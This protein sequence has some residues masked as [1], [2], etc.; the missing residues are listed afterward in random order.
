[1]HE[2]IRKSSFI[3]V[4]IGELNLA[5]AL[6]ALEVAVWGGLDFDFAVPSGV[7]FGGEFKGEEGLWGLLVVEKLCHLWFKN[8]IRI[9]FGF[10]N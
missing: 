1:M 2:P 4:A 6:E 8:R 5:L 7:V 9:L 3:N 10:R